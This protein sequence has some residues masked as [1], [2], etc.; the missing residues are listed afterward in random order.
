MATLQEKA[1]LH[2]KIK[3]LEGQ[4]AAA[5]LKL[6][7][8]EDIAAEPERKWYKWGTFAFLFLVTLASGIVGARLILSFPSSEPSTPIESLSVALVAGVFGGA[9]SGMRSLN[10]RIAAGWEYENGTREPDPTDSKERFNKKLLGG[11]L[12][13]PLLGGG[14]GILVFTGARVG[15]FKT[16]QT[17]YGILFWSTL[18]GLFAKTLLD[19]LNE[20]FKKVLGK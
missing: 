16:A 10:D 18:G 6:Y 17:L 15:E 8:P 7:E 3:T 20:A 13:R 5:K 2:E 4:I 12:A 9:L 19:K 11:F 1:D 14:A